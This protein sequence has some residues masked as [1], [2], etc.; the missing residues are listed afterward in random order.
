MF[1]L[2][3]VW[4]NGWVNNHEAGD[5]RRHRGHYDVNVMEGRLCVYQC[6]L[7]F[8]SWSC[9]VHALYVYS[10]SISRP[11]NEIILASIHDLITLTWLHER[12]VDD[13]HYPFNTAEYKKMC[14]LHLINIAQ[15]E[16][17]ATKPL[18]GLRKMFNLYH[19]DSNDYYYSQ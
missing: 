13:F 14:I 17:G 4:L 3:C 7:Y 11:K 6:C 10:W 19:Y 16:V 18:L 1:S 15:W 9:D 12:L 5:L 2:I 8:L